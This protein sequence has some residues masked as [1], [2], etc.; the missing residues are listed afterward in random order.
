MA[1]T[2]DRR[3]VFDLLAELLLAVLPRNAAVPPPAPPSASPAEPVLCEPH[4]TSLREL[5]LKEAEWVWSEMEDFV[6]LIQ[7][8]RGLFIS[9]IFAAAG[10]LLGQA[11]SATRAANVQATPQTLLALRQRPDVAAVL[12]IVPLLTTLFVILMLE[13]QFQMQSLARYRFLLGVALGGGSPVWRWEKWKE[14]PEGSVR[15]Y[16]NPSNVYFGLVA[17]IL[18]GAAL[19][20]ARPAVAVASSTM[21]SSFWWGSLGVFV[22]LVV[23]A[24]SLGIRNI[25]KNKVARPIDA[26]SWNHLWP[27]P[28]PQIPRQPSGK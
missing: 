20:F 19:W 10:W 15:A 16:T 3:G 1:D 2:H 26:N 8:Y 11:L 27:G 23:L 14:T 24:I 5:Q 25:R 13:A 18:P 28:P 6:R 22:S 9:A 7:R 17:L 21:L 12:C 4:S